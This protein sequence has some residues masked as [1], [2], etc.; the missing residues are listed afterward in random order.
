[1][2]NAAVWP[3]TA[4]RAGDGSLSIGNVP[5]EALVGEFG[6]PLYIYDVA[7]IRQQCRSYQRAFLDAYPQSRVV[8]AGKAWI[9]QALLEVIAG[10]GLALDVVSAGELAIAL[11]SGFPADRIHFHGNNKTPDELRF[12]LDSG[13][14]C[15][16]IDN[17]DEI[18]LLEQLTTGSATPLEVMLRLNPGID[19]HTH[20]YRKTGIPDSKFGLGILTGDAARAVERIASVDGLR[21]RGYHAHVGSQIFEIEPFVETVNAI[22]AFAADMRDRFGIVPDEISPGGGFGIPY[23]STDPLTPVEAYAGA[24]AQATRLAAE[25]WDL[26]DPYPR[27]ADLCFRRWRHG[28]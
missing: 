27:C 13:I 16:I 14:G 20:E 26:P 15:V 6:T 28:R 8:Y 24:V 25:R 10:E 4:K 5:V 11:A 1:M 17:F 2:E 23:E 19:V 12:A 22:F 21:L 9:S 7:T 18:D 3:I